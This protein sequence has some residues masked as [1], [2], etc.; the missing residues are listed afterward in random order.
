MGQ[1]QSRISVQHSFASWLP[2]SFRSF[3]TELMLCDLKN[4]FKW[5]EEIC[6]T[7]EGGAIFINRIFD[8]RMIKFSVSF[9]YEKSS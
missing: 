6:L 5:D 1:N 9:I 2:A 3:G 4:T 8:V 7:G